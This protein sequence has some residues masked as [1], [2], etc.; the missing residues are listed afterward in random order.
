MLD[1]MGSYSESDVS[2]QLLD[3]GI[4]WIESNYLTWAQPLSLPVELAESFPNALKGEETWES[5]DTCNINV[6]KMLYI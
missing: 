6:L 1:A 3:W 5:F 4:P 2:N